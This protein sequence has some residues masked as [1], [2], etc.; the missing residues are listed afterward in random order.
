MSNEAVK[1]KMMKL[2]YLLLFGKI[3]KPFEFASKAD[4]LGNRIYICQLLQHR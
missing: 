3:K 2:K 1:Y 4:T